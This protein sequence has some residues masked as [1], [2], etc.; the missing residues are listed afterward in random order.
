MLLLV[1]IGLVC[2][3]D[4]QQQISAS[5]FAAYNAKQS[6]SLFEKILPISQLQNLVI[7]YLNEWENVETLIDH[8]SFITTIAFSSDGNDLFSGAHEAILKKW[9]KG[10]ANTWKYVE[11]IKN[12]NKFLRFKSL[13]LSR[14]GKVAFGLNDGTIQ[15]WDRARPNIKWEKLTH[16]NYIYTVCSVKFSWDCTYLASA[17]TDNTIKIWQQDNNKQWICIQTLEGHQDA[18]NSVAFSPDGNYLAS[19]SGG[20]QDGTIK[21][22]QLAENRNWRFKQNLTIPATSLKSIE[23]AH[24]SM[25][26]AIV[27]SPDGK[28]LVSASY[29]KSIKIWQQN[30]NS[31]WRWVQNLIGHTDSVNSLAFSPDSNYVASVSHDK[32]I[33]IWQKNNNV[34]TCIQTLEGHT[35]D[36]DAVAFS[37]DGR[38]LASGSHDQ[39]IKIWRNHIL[40]ILDQ[41]RQ[42]NR[43]HDLWKCLQTRYHTSPVN[44]VAFSPDGKYII[45]GCVHE[46][47][48]RLWKQGDTGFSHFND[49]N[50]SFNKFTS[51]NSV[52]FSCDGKIAAGL[53]IG[54]N[55]GVLAIFNQGKWHNMPDSGMVR[56]VAFSAKGNYVAY[57]SNNIIKIVERDQNKSQTL[58]GHVGTVNSLIFSP[59]G[60]YV[61]SGSFDKTIKIWQQ[62]QNKQ[63][64]CVQTLT[65][66]VDMVNGVTFS[67]NGNY[68][69][70]ASNDKTIK[71][72]QQDNNNQWT[73]IQTLDDHK[74]FVK[75]VAFSPDG[76]YLA[77]ASQNGIIKI[78]QLHNNKWICIQTLLG[79]TDTISSLIFSPDGN[80][81]VS[82]SYDKT[83]KIW[84]NQKSEILDHTQSYLDMKD[85]YE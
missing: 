22:W 81:L 17:S 26:S 3:L 33:K 38:Y 75:T 79:H 5:Q 65:D 84:H 62:D 55:E 83:I 24:D 80:C 20:A 10:Y 2:V 74:S 78:W 54:I 53:T 31:N 30:V 76:N 51:I 50:F 41:I 71:I 9:K 85:G 47:L 45:S 32:T 13:T 72:W 56:S 25:I 67:P 73:C 19:G 82:G 69:A 48:M 57:A 64:V 60:K 42:N 29:D 8:E 18:V 14:D 12:K 36:I 11:T 28:Y 43:I 27:F 34:W 63:W 23:V 49:K 77:S 39:T 46:G 58:K 59:N 7:A 70:S 4:A 16:S 61:T 44:S 1:L 35:G 52:T 37:P 15:I 40:E 66:H 68:I 6:I 21:I